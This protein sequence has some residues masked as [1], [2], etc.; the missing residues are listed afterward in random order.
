[1]TLDEL[2]RRIVRGHWIV[3]TVC[4]LVPVAATLL[5]QTR[6]QRGYVATVRL[7]VSASAPMSTIEADA[8]GSRVLA[9]ASTPSVVRTALDEAGLD[10]ADA[11]AV[12]RDAVSSRRLG[13]S[14]VVELSVSQASRRDAVALVGTLADAVTTFMNDAN[15]G[16]FEKTLAAVDKDL[17]AATAR[18][19][20]ATQRLTHARDPQAP[21]PD[22]VA[23]A[24]AAQAAVDQL[25]DTKASM[26]VA[27]A[28]RDR[29]VVVDGPDPEVAQ[30]P[31]ALLP[32]TALALLLG[33]LVGLGLAVTLE[34]L[35]PRLAGLRALARRFDAPVLGNAEQRPAALANA[36]TMAA[37]RQGIETVVM[38]GVDDADDAT[39][40][41]LLAGFGT[42]SRHPTARGRTLQSQM[43][44]GARPQSLD[45]GNGSALPRIPDQVRFT[46]LAGVGPVDERTAGVVLVSSEAPL[47]RDVDTVDDILRTTRWPV[48]GV[49]GV[50]RLVPP[51]AEP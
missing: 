33:L 39:A 8:I 20:K 6:A 10:P 40:H 11:T 13:Q 15:R 26:T 30:A 47:Q 1:M 49:V 36:I 51:R 7:Q 25:A 50:H 5:L 32:R 48:L 45:A 14:S 31:S 35:R 23:A 18:L 41:R 12:A 43:H 44:G 22:L 34:T 21:R 27:D 46:H 4:L 9:L 19:S 29:V 28:S 3:I 2:L 24:G 38:L 17:A 16:E 37:R 42:P